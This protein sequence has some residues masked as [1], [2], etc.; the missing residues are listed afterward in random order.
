MNFRVSKEH[1]MDLIFPLA[2]LLVF[3]ASAVM[4]VLLAADVYADTTS[5]SGRAHNART[6]TAYVTEKIHQNDAEGGVTLV[7]AGDRNALKLQRTVDHTIY[8]TYLYYYNGSLCEL[9]CLEGA[10]VGPESGQEILPLQDFQ[11]DK[12]SDRLFR[13]RCLDQENC[14]STAYVAVQSVEE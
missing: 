13:F 12:L 10:Q 14:L 6:V 5:Q 8:N 1:V 4:V 7:E 2:L 11:V 3:A 9:L